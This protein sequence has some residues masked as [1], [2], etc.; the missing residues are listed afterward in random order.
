MGKKR[1]VS[2]RRLAER[3]IKNY[4]DRFTDGFEENKRL[5]SEV[6]NIPSRTMRNQVAGYIHRLNRRKSRMPL[7]TMPRL[8]VPTSFPRKR[9]GRRGR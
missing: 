7:P 3:L 9:R 1:A 5:I 2:V 6:V 8:S 4:P